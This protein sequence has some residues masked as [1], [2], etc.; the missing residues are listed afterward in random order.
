VTSQEILRWSFHGDVVLWVVLLFLSGDVSLFVGPG[1]SWCGPSAISLNSKVVLSSDKLHETLFSPVSTPR[2]SYEPEWSSVLF[3]ISNE[4]DLVDNIDITCL[5]FEDSRGIVLHSLCDGNTAC[6]WA[7][8]VDLLHH[9]LLSREMSE[10]INS[11]DQIFI[12]DETSLMVTVFASADWRAF[13]AV[14]IASGLIN[15][16]SLISHIVVV[17]PFISIDWLTTMATLILGLT[18]NDDLWGDVD[19]GPSS[20]SSNLDSI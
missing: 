17:H 16:A 10:L 3:T 2:V 1:I 11:V 20:L 7:S 5:I 6:N 19:I 18:R 13:N 4:T 15:G 12:W 14:I 9:G 8:L